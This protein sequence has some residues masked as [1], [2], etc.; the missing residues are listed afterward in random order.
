MTD[1]K[2]LF[3]YLRPGNVRRN[4]LKTLR[5][6][7]DWRIW[8]FVAIA[9][10]VSACSPTYDW[11]IV[12]VDEYAYEALYPS[13][14]TRAEKTIVVGDQ[15][16]TMVMQASKAADALFAVGVITLDAGS[17]QANEIVDWLKKSTVRNLK[18]DHEPQ[19]QEQLS[20]K[21]AGNT[22]E[23][24]SASG[25]KLEGWGP[26]QIPRILWVRWLKRKDANGIERIYQV[27]VLQSLDKSFEQQRHLR[28]QLEEQVETFYAGFH[29]Y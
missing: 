11:R 28:S 6:I 22:K 26:D 23:I 12:K 29:P 19:W 14:P 21:A 9:A 1:F 5:F 15:K 8:S 2:A 27:S 20:F 10:F 7:N 3:P 13:K 24:I 25:L 4:R 16:L 18:S 17:N